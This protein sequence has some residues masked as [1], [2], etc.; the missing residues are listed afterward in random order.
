MRS[1]CRLI[2]GRLALLGWSRR[3]G[4][5][6]LLGIFLAS[7]FRIVLC[8]NSADYLPFSLLL[9]LNKFNVGHLT[10]RRRWNEK[11]ESKN[12]ASEH[13]RNMED[14][15]TACCFGHLQ[16]TFGI[17][18]L[19]M[20]HDRM[21][22]CIAHSKRDIQHEHPNDHQ[23]RRTSYMHLPE[24]GDELDVR[25]HVGRFSELH[26]AVEDWIGHHKHDKHD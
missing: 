1:R 21:I 16:N 19:A 3:R 18:R 12:E 6:L 13:H 8:L 14:V 11:E 4:L 15:R 17:Q 10:S 7:F 2:F 26:E 20:H 22:V 5:N 25:S 9:V 24:R 23:R